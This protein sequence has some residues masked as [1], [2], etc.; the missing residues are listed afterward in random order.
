MNYIIG[1]GLIAFL[2]KMIL[3]DYIIIPTGKSRYFKYN[4]ATCDDYII[5]HKEIDGFIHQF[6]TQFKAP[7]VAIFFKRALSYCGQLIF[8]KNEFINA[9]IHKVYGNDGNPFTSELIKFDFFVYNISSTD[10]FKIIEPICK[11]H[12]KDFIQTNDSLNFIDINNKIIYTKHKQLE[13]ENI[14]STIPLDAMFKYCN[15]QRE[16]KSKDLHTF[17]VETESLNFEGASELLVVDD[18]IDFFKCTRLRETIYQ[19]FSSIEIQNLPSYINL[20]INKY[21]L[22]SATVVRKAIPLGDIKQHEEL[23][24]YNIYCIGSNAQWDDMVDVSSCIL[25]LL[26]FKS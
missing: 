13:Y 7:I 19:F 10:L 8:N 16:L 21:N 25:R 24:K 11:P 14:I 26:R 15:I 2:A 23:N 1:S 12:F 18:N 3:P 6:T 5:C 17:V 22:L 9:W 20:F 4:V